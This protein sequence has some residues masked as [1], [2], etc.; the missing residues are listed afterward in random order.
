MRY[1]ALLLVLAM[2]LAIR[3][4]AENSATN[5]GN[6]TVTLP[7]GTAENDIVFGGGGYSRNGAAFPNITTAG[8]VS[9][10]TAGAVGSAALVVE[11]KVMGATPDS[12]FV[13]TGSGNVDDGAA[14]VAQVWTGADTTTPDDAT[15]TTATGTDT[16]PDTPAIVTAT[17]GAI[18]QSW[19][20]KQVSD[21]TV[22]GPSG[23]SNQVDINA[24]D[25]TN[26]STVGCASILVA[27]PASENPGA[28]SGVGT[29]G[30]WAG[31]TCAIRPAVEVVNVGWMPPPFSL[32]RERPRVIA[33]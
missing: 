9:I 29:G 13:G 2:A 27:S 14:Y 20:D 21:T 6:V 25:Q 10:V 4:V 5:G 33:Y 17:A 19:F 30:E 7:V 1:L 24:N 23:Y 22:T 16:Q 12:T 26:D 32:P 28:W 3:G 11:R 31:A 18:V 8:Y 15:P